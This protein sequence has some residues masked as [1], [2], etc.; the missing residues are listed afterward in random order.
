MSELCSTNSLVP[1]TQRENT[2]FKNSRDPFELIFGAMAPTGLASR[3]LFA[4]W[5][6]GQ[7][8]APWFESQLYRLLV[9]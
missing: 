8:L 9:G 4:D 3:T 5:L 6:T 1:L 2:I 7:L